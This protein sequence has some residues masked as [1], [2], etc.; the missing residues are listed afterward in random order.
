MSLLAV[1]EAVKLDLREVVQRSAG[2]VS[3]AFEKRFQLGRGSK[4]SGEVSLPPDS[5]NKVLSRHRRA[6]SSREEYKY[7]SDIDSSTKQE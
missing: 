4:D 7:Y 1:T 5:C 6:N 3:M 2:K